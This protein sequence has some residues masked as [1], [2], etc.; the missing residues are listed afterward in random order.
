MDRESSMGGVSVR[1]SAGG[2][3]TQRWSRGL[4]SHPREKGVFG[5]PPKLVSK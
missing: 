5:S 1:G 2:K 3:P 4:P